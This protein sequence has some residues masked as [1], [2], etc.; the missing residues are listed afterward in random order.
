[1]GQ[2]FVYIGHLTGEEVGGGLVGSVYQMT[3]LHCFN[4]LWYVACCLVGAFLFH[5]WRSAVHT[6]H[7]DVPSLA[8]GQRGLWIDVSE[9][10]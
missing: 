2:T 5:Y 6:C 9:P 3:F 10:L 4:C 7:A 8:D 1:M